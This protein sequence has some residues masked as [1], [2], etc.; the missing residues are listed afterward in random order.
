[1]LLNK[2]SL[3]SD[4]IRRFHS[5]DEIIIYLVIVTVD[6]DVLCAKTV[7]LIFGFPECSH[8]PKRWTVVVEIRF[9]SWGCI[10][11]H[12]SWP[13]RISDTHIQIPRTSRPETRITSRRC[14]A[15]KSALWTCNYS[16][17]SKVEASPRH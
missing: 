12:S 5:S 2:S 1:L 10:F 9:G 8:K 15:P 11:I 16:D 14:Q 4:S 3:N 7:S 6:P 13:V 17:F